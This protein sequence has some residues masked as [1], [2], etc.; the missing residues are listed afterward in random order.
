VEIVPLFFQKSTTQ[1][2][3]GMLPP[4][5][6]QVLGRDIYVREGCYNCH[7]QMIRPMRAETMRYG[8]PS[9]LEESIFDHPFQWGSKRTGPDL[10]RE[11]GRYP[12][13]WHLRHLADPRST[14]PG[15][16]MPAYPHLATARVDLSATAGKLEAMRTVGVPYPAAQIGAASQI[17][18]AEANVIAEDLRANGARVAADSEAVALIAYLQ[19]LGRMQGNPDTAAA[20]QAATP[21]H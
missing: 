19:R 6:L 4:T 15:S 17:A 21:A 18:T 2:I 10:A 20:V 11:G 13:L 14:S 16:N 5:S 1:P 9:R 3:T 12:N 7:S 8:E